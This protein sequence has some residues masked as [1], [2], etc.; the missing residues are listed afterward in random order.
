[1]V[2]HALVS[3]SQQHHT[4]LH[5]NVEIY[6]DQVTGLSF[7]ALR[8]IPPGTRLVDCS[9]QTTLSYLNA[10]DA[11]PYFQRHSTPFPPHF[12]NTLKQDDPNVIGHFFLVQ[13]YLL[14]PASFWFQYIRLLPQPYQPE[15][16]GIPVW[17]P[18][19]DRKYLDGTNADPPIKIRKSLW[20][21]EWK[22]GFS[23][24]KEAFEGW[25][26]YTYFLYQWAATIFGSRSFRPSLTIP[27]SFV[28]GP[29]AFAEDMYLDVAHV[30]KD[31]FS[32]L[33]PVMDIGNH[34]GAN[35]VVWSQ[36]PEAGQFSLSNLG[37][38]EKGSQIYNYYGD[39]SNSELLVAYGFTLPDT[40]KD[41][42]N[43][44]LTPDSES[45]RL[46]RSQTS[47][48]VDS[49]QPEQE[50]M[51]QV[52]LHNATVTNQNG[53]PE[54]QVFSPGLV[55]TMSC[56]VSTSR[57]RRFI[58]SNNTYSLE[59]AATVFS[60]PLARN[61]IHVLRILHDKL[62]YELARIHKSGEGLK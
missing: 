13:Q 42:V 3:W 24:L 44:R 35:Q 59:E 41:L 43:L 62:L 23:L 10:I 19:D 36:H 26:Q 40:N 47:H 45:N 54:L 9:Y 34:N 50:F 25:E 33:L 1:M 17:W 31:R 15:T 49:N 52:K 11:V 48:I 60:G 39:K 32:V 56:M 8:D 5:P 37:P 38:V 51:F 53:L 27:E 21:E 7:R 6:H 14:G 29:D 22:R 20:E 16:F 57:E 30:R 4:S 28:R 12:I 55:D 46:R 2:V 58:I 18:E 61:I